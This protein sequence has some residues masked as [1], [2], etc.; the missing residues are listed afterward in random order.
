MQ[1]PPT[2]PTRYFVLYRLT[3]TFSKKE[4]GTES[5]LEEDVWSGNWV[6]VLVYTL[7][8]AVIGRK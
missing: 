2:Q 4:I 8:I 7:L 1:L 3:E 6:L 5:C